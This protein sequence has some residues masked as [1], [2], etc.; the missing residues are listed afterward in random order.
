MF[1]SRH[2][3]HVTTLGGVTSD[4]I[5][6][7]FPVW[8]TCVISTSGWSAERTPV[9]S[10]QNRRATTPWWP[11]RL[12]EFRLDPVSGWSASMADRINA[13]GL[14]WRQRW[15]YP[16]SNGGGVQISS[17]SSLPY[18]LLTLQILMALEPKWRRFYT[19]FNKSIGNLTHTDP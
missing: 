2:S 19:C 18:R 13:S 10:A 3:Q 14:Y 9:R 16:V 8:V 7:P 15:R 4:P 11:C 17:A 5:S 6:F 1:T 12:G